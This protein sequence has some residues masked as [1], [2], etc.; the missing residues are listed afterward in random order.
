[1]K[2]ADWVAL[3]ALSLWLLALDIRQTGY[4]VPLQAAVQR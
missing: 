3:E 1:V 2:E 4:A